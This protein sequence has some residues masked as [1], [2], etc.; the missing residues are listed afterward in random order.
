VSDLFSPAVAVTPT[1]RR[2]FLWAAW[3][4]APPAREPFRKPDAAQGGAR[5]R[6][7]ALRAAARAAGRPL[8]EIDPSW[9]RAWARILVGEDPWPRR[10]AAPPARRAAG[11]PPISSW[12]LLGV[13]PDAT[14]EELKRAYR[15]RALAAHPDRGG[16]AA[17]FR[18]L[19]RAYDAAVKKRRRRPRRRAP[20]ASAPGRPLNA[21]AASRGSRAAAAPSR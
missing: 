6:E 1:R 16:D 2:R 11:P 9:A 3:W 5:S 18:E 17:A 10:G 7:E 19:K 8:T 20:G 21:R 14:L 13:A 4:T 15:Q 12:Q